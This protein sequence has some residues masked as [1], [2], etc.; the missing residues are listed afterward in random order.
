M[1][2][3]GDGPGLTNRL[4]L[5]NGFGWLNGLRLCNVFDLTL[6]RLALRVSNIED[7]GKVSLPYSRQPVSETLFG[8]GN[9]QSQRPVAGASHVLA[10]LDFVGGENLDAFAPARD[11]HVPLL[12]ACCR[13]DG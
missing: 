5:R 6:R 11:G 12:C 3:V 10:K 4:R 8:P 2:L 9:I 1:F 13:F 7:V